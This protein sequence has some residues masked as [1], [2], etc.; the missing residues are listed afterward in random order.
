MPASRLK[1]L[2]SSRKKVSK[3]R[4][5]SGASVAPRDQTTA[6]TNIRSMAPV[7]SDESSI[8]T[9]SGLAGEG[10]VLPGA[11]GCGGSMSRTIRQCRRLHNEA[12]RPTS[13]CGMSCG[14]VPS[15]VLRTPTFR[16]AGAVAVPG[17]VVAVDVGSISD[18]GIGERPRRKAMTLSSIAKCV[19]RRVRTFS[20]VNAT[21]S[22]RAIQDCTLQEVGG[23][24]AKPPPC[25]HNGRSPG[26]TLATR[27]R[28]MQRIR[29]RDAR[30]LRET[31]TRGRR[32]QRGDAC[33]VKA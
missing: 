19:A 23:W 33:W 29:R 1:R 15:A 8:V 12:T 25:S 28:L 16:G 27:G 26:Q 4:Q 17:A 6:N 11:T 24:G 31:Q 13:D 10:L 22:G 20:D 7:A 30:Q 3:A 9:Q 5:R 14:C 21:T 32:L 2:R 18:D